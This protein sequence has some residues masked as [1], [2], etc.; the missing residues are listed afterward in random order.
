MNEKTGAVQRHCSSHHSHH[1][2]AHQYLI[3]RVAVAVQRG[4][5]AAILGTMAG[6]MF[7][8]L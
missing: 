6:G 5:A 3:Q 7:N 1:T 2:I 8:D 4:N